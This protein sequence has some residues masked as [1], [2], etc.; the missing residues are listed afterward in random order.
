[1][2][3]NLSVA[4]SLV[5]IATEAEWASLWEL[6]RP[7]DLEYFHMMSERRAS[8]EYA[9]V[10]RYVELWELLTSRVQQKLV[11][12]EWV[13]EGFPL[14]EPIAPQEINAR[15]W[16]DLYFD[17]DGN[18]CSGRFRIVGIRVS[19]TQALPPTGKPEGR[20][21]RARLRKW[22]EDLSYTATGSMIRDD[23]FALAL[24]QHPHARFTR[25]SF[26]KAWEQAEKR[27]SFVQSGRPK[28]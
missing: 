11:S 28:S 12:G 19:D 4:E 21:P 13:A 24:E 1:M 17:L 23:V 7:T 18:A 26:D 5:H 25:Y 10:R 14:G 2:F 9:W 15:L 20:L 27:P 6:R 8:A 16:P 22:I 3:R